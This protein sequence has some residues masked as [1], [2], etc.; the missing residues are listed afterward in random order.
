MGQYGYG[1]DS[2]LAYC[3]NQLLQLNLV[4]ARKV[5]DLHLRVAELENFAN[6]LQTSEEPN[7]VGDPNEADE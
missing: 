1:D 2:Q 3:V 6:L 4:Q 7:D 5:A